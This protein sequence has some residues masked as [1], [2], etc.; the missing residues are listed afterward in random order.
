[1]C[2]ST[3]RLSLP[4]I[5]HFSSTFSPASLLPRG[6]DGATT[7]TCTKDDWWWCGVGWGWGGGG[8]GAGRGRGEGEWVRGVGCGVWVGGG[9]GERGGGGVQQSSSLVCQRCAPHTHPSSPEAWNFSPPFRHW[10]TLSQDLEDKL[11]SVFLQFRV[12]CVFVF[13][14]CKQMYMCIAFSLSVLPRVASLFV[15]RFVSFRL[16]RSRCLLFS[17]VALS[18][19]FQ[20]PFPLDLDLFVSLYRSL[21]W[22]FS[23][24]LSSSL[25][26]FVFCFG[27]AHVSS[28]VCCCVLGRFK[29]L[30]AELSA[31]CSHMCVSHKKAEHGENV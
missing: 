26:I 11:A 12:M 8:E 22:Y 15:S 13:V 9:G 29:V 7:P 5:K 1:M 19:L 24:W 23:L 3:S 6:T 14:H 18:L 16:V 10:K 27:H 25:V 4:V 17:C 30:C 28:I 20:V 2:S 31:S 21:C